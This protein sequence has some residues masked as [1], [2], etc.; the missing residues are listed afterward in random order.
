MG[1]EQ[2]RHLVALLQVVDQ[3]EDLF[4]DGDVE[5]GRG[6][7]GDQELGLAGDG[8]RDHHPL[9][10]AA[11]HLR[12]VGVDLEFRVGNA[13]FGE[14][15]ERALP[16]VR[17]RETEMQPQHLGQLKADGEHRVERG[18]RLLEDH[19]DVGAAQP[20]QLGQIQVEQIDASVHDLAARQNGRVFLGQEA[21]HRQRGDALAAARFADQRDGRVGRYVEADALHRLEGGVLVQAEVDPQVANREERLR[22]RLRLIGC[23]NFSPLTSTSDR[24]RR[25]ARR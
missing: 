8:H 22:H 13:D 9:L 18:H 23:V 2:H 12:R 4:L 15:G 17:R 11:G 16:R 7:V 14:Q 3:V 19:R 5:G 10:L 1:D 24:A 20:P 6:L 21:E 25:A